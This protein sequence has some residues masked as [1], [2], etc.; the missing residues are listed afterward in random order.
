MNAI[1]CPNCD[2]FN[3]PSR[4]NCQKCNSNLNASSFD[5]YIERPDK[6]SVGS[7]I[8]LIV[9]MIVLFGF[10]IFAIS[11]SSLFSKSPTKE[12]SSDREK[13]GMEIWQKHLEL[14]GEKDKPEP[15]TL[16][17]KATAEISPRLNQQNV[18][19]PVKAKGETEYYFKSPN[20]IYSR[21][22]VELPRFRTDGTTSILIQ[23]YFDGEKGWEKKVE[24]KGSPVW[25]GSKVQEKKTETLRQ[26][27]ESEIAFFKNE[28]PRILNERYTKILFNGEFGNS[29]G[30]TFVIHAEKKSGEINTIYLNQETYLISKIEFSGVYNRNQNEA[31]LSIAFSNY[32]NIN[33]FQVPFDMDV[34]TNPTLT[35]IR[36]S[37]IQIDSKIDDN[38]F[39]IK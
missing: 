20:K 16:I 27:N 37:E 14:S 5:Y 4:T 21:S 30:K 22:G 29:E 24:V 10:G 1:P 38:F 3:H 11:Q 15:K 9:G 36:C 19:N 26:L 17:F 34:S 2:F 35:K 23:K 8:A 18:V 39:E 31:V 7:K 13:R 25:D 6:S 32:K 33:G 28:M 12:S